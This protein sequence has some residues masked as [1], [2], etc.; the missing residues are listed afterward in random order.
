V[1]SRWDTL[2]PGRSLAK[3]L[4]PNPTSDTEIRKLLSDFFAGRAVPV[5]SSTEAVIEEEANEE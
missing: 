2:H 1:Q 3:G 4:P 5:L